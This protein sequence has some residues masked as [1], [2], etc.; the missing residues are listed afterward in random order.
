MTRFFF[1]VD[2][3]KAGYF[4]DG[5]W[6]LPPIHTPSRKEM[7]HNPRTDV[8]I[9]AADDETKYAIET[10]LPAMI[11]RNN[12]CI[13]CRVLDNKAAYTYKKPY[14]ADC[15]AAVHV[16]PDIPLDLG[17]TAK[18]VFKAQNYEEKLGYLRP[19]DLYR[20]PPY[21]WHWVKNEQVQVMQDAVRD[22]FDLEGRC[23]RCAETAKVTARDPYCADCLPDVLF[24]EHEWA[25]ELTE[26]KQLKKL[27]DKEQ[28][29]H[30][31]D[32]EE[33]SKTVQVKTWGDASV[34]LLELKKKKDKAKTKLE[35][36]KDK[37]RDHVLVKQPETGRLKKM[38]KTIIEYD[39]KKGTLDSIIKNQI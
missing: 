15:F 3:T 19:D 5:A 34:K 30:P 17:L 23:V 2:M 13:R 18:E 21:E 22:A 12:T 35:K 36:E 10:G 7:I 16:Y 27:A 6:R 31:P 8:W 26:R 20:D 32:Q 11:R 29:W 24:S 33:V 9:W 14:C 28:E 39:K 1:D 38:A 37:K 25:K 4:V